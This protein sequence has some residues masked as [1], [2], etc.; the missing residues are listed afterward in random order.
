[1]EEDGERVNK[2]FEKAPQV[3][4]QV[5]VNF[6]I[7]PDFII[8]YCFKY[9]RLVHLLTFITFLVEQWRSITGE[10]LSILI[11][12]GRYLAIALVDKRKLRYV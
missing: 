6:F 10:E 9:G 7:C 2:L 8:C 4:I 12:S 3:G 11:L 5:Q 1:M